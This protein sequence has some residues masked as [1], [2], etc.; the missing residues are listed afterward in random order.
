MM[1]KQEQFLNVIDR[2]EA[3]RR[4]HAAIHLAPLGVEQ[5][6]LAASLGRVLAADVVSPVDVPSFDRSNFDGFAVRAVDTYGASEE[7]PRKLALLADVIATSVV[8]TCEVASGQAAAIATGGM[9]PR[10]ADAVVM[11]EDAD[12]SDAN[13]SIRRAVTPGSASPLQ[14]PIS[15]PARPCCAWDSS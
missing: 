3:E 11:V 1:S 7:Q 10:G 2:D 5:V 4:F 13:V 15:P 12:N 14:E 9:M 6:E 8:P